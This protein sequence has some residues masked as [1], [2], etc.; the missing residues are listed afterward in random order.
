MRGKDLYKDIS[1]IG[2]ELIEKNRPAIYK[3]RHAVPAVLAAAAC[4]L[5]VLAGIYIFAVITQDNN[6][7]TDNTDYKIITDY[8]IKSN[9]N[10]STSP[11]YAAPMGGETLLVREIH[12]A[13]REYGDEN[14]KFLLAV[15]IKEYYPNF[16]PNKE[17]DNRLRGEKLDAELKRLTDLGY[18][19][20]EEKI[21][22]FINKGEKEWYTVIV[23]LFTKE[24]LLEFPAY[25]DYGYSFQFAENGDGTSVEF[26]KT[27]T[28]LFK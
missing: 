3:R 9:G 23:G 17:E 2:D 20:Y 14:V 22:H 1:L 5:I 27:K 8:R 10:S 12:E 21:W 26:D 16:D 28:P 11:C 24:Q 6:I 25:K 4:V 15:D 18:E 19:F 7:F 13:F